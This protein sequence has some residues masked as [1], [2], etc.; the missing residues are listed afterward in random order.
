M[1]AS[2]MRYDAVAVLTQEQHLRVPRIRGQRPAMGEHYRLSR[3]PVLEIDLCTIFCSSRIHV[4]FSLIILVRGR[5]VH[6]F[7]MNGKCRCWQPH[8]CDNGCT[9]DED[10]AAQA[11][12]ILMI[13]LICYLRISLTRCLPLISDHCV[14]LFLSVGSRALSNASVEPQTI[15][16]IDFFPPIFR[17]RRSL[18]NGV[19]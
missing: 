8:G 6:S 13:A 3:T 19:S 2:V 12:D 10:V 4:T 9:T 15:S 18:C 17:T 16:G 14:L 7:W 1:T 11:I 5:S